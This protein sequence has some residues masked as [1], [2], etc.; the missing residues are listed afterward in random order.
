MNLIASNMLLGFSATV[1][2]LVKISFKKKGN[3][4]NETTENT[5]ERILVIKYRTIFPL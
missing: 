5:I 2:S 3:A 4:P 1:W